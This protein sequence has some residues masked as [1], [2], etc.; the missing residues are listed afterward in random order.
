MQYHKSKQMR[1]IL[2]SLPKKGEQNDHY[3]KVKDLNNLPLEELMSL[4]E[5]HEIVM[6]NY[7][8]VNKKKASWVLKVSIP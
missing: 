3:W 8:E 4:L 1:K 6:N 2:R 5:T 7:D